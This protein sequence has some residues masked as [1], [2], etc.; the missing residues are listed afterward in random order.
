MSHWGFHRVVIDENEEFS[1]ARQGVGNGDDPTAD[2]I[3]ILISMWR[4]VI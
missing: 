2:G 1:G 4:V 3:S